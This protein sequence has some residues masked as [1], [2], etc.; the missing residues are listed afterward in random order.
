MGYSSR[1]QKIVLYSP[2]QNTVTVVCL[3]TMF[4]Q[5]KCFYLLFSSYINSWIP[6]FILV[7]SWKISFCTRTPYSM[8]ETYITC[9]Y[10]NVEKY[11]LTLKKL[12]YSNFLQCIVY[13]SSNVLPPQEVYINVKIYLGVMF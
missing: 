6:L 3:L 8:N 4:D 11:Y 7:I 1:R 9:M 10:K 5:L 12:E 13:V 2:K